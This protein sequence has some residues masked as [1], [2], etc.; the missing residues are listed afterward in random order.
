MPKVSTVAALDL[1]TGNMPNPHEAKEGVFGGLPYLEYDYGYVVRLPG[2]S[3]DDIADKAPAWMRRVAEAAFARKVYII[4]FD[5]DA[6]VCPHL[7]EWDW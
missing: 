1:S 2:C 6:A 7:P 4:Q 3:W 5:C